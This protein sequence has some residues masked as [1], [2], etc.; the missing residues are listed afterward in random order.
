MNDKS[1]F[2]AKD[3]SFNASGYEWHFGDGDSATG[4]H[5]VH[6]Y[7]SNKT[8]KASLRIETGSGCKNELDSSLSITESGIKVNNGD[9]FALMA[10]PNPFSA[11]TTVQYYLSATTSIR[12][13]LMDMAGKQFSIIPGETEE[14]GTYQLDIIAD[15]YNLHPGIYILKLETGD[16]Y[17]TRELVKF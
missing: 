8:Y 14:Q 4:Y 10:Y 11:V 5:A 17:S 1:I 13:N 7:P 3:T 15:R 9:V 16:G 2:Y 6:L 12:I